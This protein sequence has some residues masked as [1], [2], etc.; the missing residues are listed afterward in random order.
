MFTLKNLFIFDIDGTIA[1]NRHRLHHILYDDPRKKD[2]DSYD[3]L[4]AD[5]EPIHAVR[6]LV[7]FL[8]NAGANV[9]YLTGRNERGRANTLRWLGW[10]NIAP[11]YSDQLV[12]RGL[13]DYRD[14]GTMKLEYL[15][16]RGITPADVRTIFD[17]NNHVVR[18]L[19]DA[20]YHVCHVADDYTTAV[21]E[22]GPGQFD[23]EEVGLS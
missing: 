1:D 23:D 21:H 5:D 3:A 16:K 22:G 20:G 8:M 10:H 12:M 18:S 6:D 19:R 9:M 17:D 11:L 13:R 4:W 2:W 7:Q 15:D 14:A